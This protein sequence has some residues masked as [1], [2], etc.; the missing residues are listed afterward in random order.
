MNDRPIILNHVYLQRTSNWNIVTDGKKI[1][2]LIPD[3]TYHLQ[4]TISD[5]KNENEIDLTLSI[6]KRSKVDVLQATCYMSQPL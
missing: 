1:F 4:W 6:H 3:P 2:F 5:I